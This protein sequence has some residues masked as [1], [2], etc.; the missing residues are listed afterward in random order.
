[1]KKISIALL[2]ILFLSQVAFSQSN[3]SNQR[4]TFAIS[5]GLVDFKSAA[6]VK[7]NNL[8]NT[9]NN[10]EF[11]KI[12]NM[13]PA[14]AVSYIK[15]LSSNLDVVGT[16]AGS[17]VDYPMPN[18]TAFGRDFLLMEGDCSVRGKFISSKTVSPYLQAGVGVS[19]FKSYYGAFIPVGA[20]IQID[21]L[22]EAYLLVNAQYR[23]P[24][25]EA[26]N[27]HFFYGIGIGGNIGK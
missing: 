4:T 16:F 15:G 21:L 22:K 8:G 7:A 24:V 17:F 5:F 23:I 2:S 6:A 3:A 9:I 11:G 26:T 25:S 10:Q 20:G 12:K 14:L 18:R 19:K 27:Y 1:M 13:A